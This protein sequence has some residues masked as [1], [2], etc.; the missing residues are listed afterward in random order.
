MRKVKLVRAAAFVLVLSAAALVRHNWVLQTFY[1]EHMRPDADGDDGAQCKLPDYD[2]LDASIRDYVVR[3]WPK[4]DCASTQ[5]PLTY[6]DE[7]K[8]LVVNRTAAQKY[9]GQL[10]CTVQDVRR[11]PGDDDHVII[12]PKKVITGEEGLQSEFCIVQCVELPTRRV[13]Y[14]TGYAQVVDVPAQQAKRSREAAKEGRLNVIVLALESMSRLNFMRQLPLSHEYITNELQGVV[15]KGLT[16]V[17]D[18]TYANMVPFLSG[19]AAGYA[20]M[21]PRFGDGNTPAG[22][23]DELP[24]TWRDFSA[25]GHV[26]MFAEDDAAITIFNY[27]AKGFKEPPTHYYMRPFWL[28]MDQQAHW[29]WDSRCYGHI[30]KFR[31][32]FDYM[33]RF[34]GKMHAENRAHFSF[35]FLS[36]LSHEAINPIQVIDSDLKG[37]LQRLKGSG[38]LD[39]SL[40]LVMGDHGNRFDSIRNTVIGRIEERMPYLAVVVPPALDHFR[41]SLKANAE[42]LTSWHDGYETVM[43]VAM[44]NLGPK[45]KKLRYGHKGLSLFRPIPA[46]RS[47][48]DIGI[49]SVYC[50]CWKEQ[51]LPTEV[52]AGLAARLLEHLN[53]FIHATDPEG[54]CAALLL[55]AVTDAQK[56]LPATGVA[57]YRDFAVHFRVTVRVRPSGALLEGTLRQDAW[58]PPQVVGDVNRIN[59]YRTWW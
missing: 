25:A 2:P 36:H 41:P 5:L 40:L 24:A 55:D 45:S 31:F 26:T 7:R 11:P 54:R 9:W 16:K 46:D 12:G 34:L 1:N 49:P 18:N 56:L 47:C 42:V 19:L 21:S 8:R 33:E 39:N 17:G 22:Y 13:V 29:A 35:T 58:S 37:L 14:E 48:F 15:M 23:S 20:E 52:A 28:A 38:V 50:V 43:D 27:M 30:P 44:L 10:E 53:A 57:H 59:R 3:P 6:L 4:I 51:E 32:L